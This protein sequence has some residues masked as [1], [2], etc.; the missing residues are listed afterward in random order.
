MMLALCAA[1]DRDPVQDVLDV[2]RVRDIP[3]VGQFRGRARRAGREDDGVLIPALRARNVR[4]DPVVEQDVVLGGLGEQV[5]GRARE[6]GNDEPADDVVRPGDEE[7]PDF[8]WEG[9]RVRVGQNLHD[10]AV[11]LL[12]DRVVDGDRIARAVRRLV[13][14]EPRLGRRVDEDAVRVRERRER[15]RED[16]REVVLVRVARDRRE[17][18][19]DRDVE[20]DLV[21]TGIRVGGEDRLPE[22]QAA[23]R[24]TLVVQNVRHDERGRDR[25]VLEPDDFRLGRPGSRA[26]GRGLPEGPSGPSAE[27]GDSRSHGVPLRPNRD[28]GGPR[29]GRYR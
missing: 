16:D 29:R 5:E 12:V 17:R 15:R 14:V 11:G 4:V 18:R 2:D 7:R 27:S 19:A 8:V 21:E 22:R 24:V 1:R 6:A 23:R 13:L 3:G 10:R 9:P 20:G 26:S 28:R 25:A